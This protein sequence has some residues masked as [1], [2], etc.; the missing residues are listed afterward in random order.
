MGVEPTIPGATV[1]KTVTFPRKISL[2]VLAVAV[3][4]I[5]G[6]WVMAPGEPSLP[7]AAREAGTQVT[8]AAFTTA[9]EQFEVDCGR[10]PSTAEGLNALITRPAGISETRWRPYLK[11]IYKDSWGRDFV[12]RCPGQHNTN[13]FDIFSYGRDGLSKSGGDDDDDIANWQKGYPQR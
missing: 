11:N 2:A 4:G 13:G 8:I 1:I 12:Y 6:W 9:L 7:P 3:L 5:A 10:F